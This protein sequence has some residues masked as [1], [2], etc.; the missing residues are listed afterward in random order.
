MK[1]IK[2][3]LYV[4]TLVVSMGLIFGGCSGDN[5]NQAEIEESHSNMEESMDKY[6]Q[7]LSSINSQTLIGEGVITFTEE[8][9]LD[10]MEEIICNIDSFVG[11]ELNYTGSISIVHGA[12]DDVYV[13]GR[14]FNQMH[15]DHQHEGVVG[16]AVIYDGEIPKEGTEVEVTGVLELG[17]LNHAVVPILKTTDIKVIE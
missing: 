4:C 9:Y 8:D 17:E 13:A 3:I 14:F 1:N 6:H 12:Y 15:G 5:G 2:K 7:T 16:L 10:K 11:R